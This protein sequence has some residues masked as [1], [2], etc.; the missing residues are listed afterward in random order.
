MRVRELGAASNST[1]LDCASGS[2]AT[3][4]DLNFQ[5]P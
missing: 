1:A 2:V 5:K 3:G 4:Q